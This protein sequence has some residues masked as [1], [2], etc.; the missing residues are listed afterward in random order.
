M[1][2]IAPGNEH[3]NDPST[4]H[5]FANAPNLH[6]PLTLADLNLSMAS[7]KPLQPGEFKLLD[8]P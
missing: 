7:I 6:G 2:P 4:N 5:S 8:S 1:I 3:A